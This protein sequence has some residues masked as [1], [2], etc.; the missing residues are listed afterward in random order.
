ML[1]GAG[2]PAGG[3]C[4]ARNRYS[5]R[6]S[7]TCAPDPS[8]EHHCHR[9]TPIL[10]PPPLVATITPPLLVARALQNLPLAPAE[11]S[12]R[13]GPRRLC[14]PLPLKDTTADWE[15]IA[16]PAI[17]ALP[18]TSHTY[19]RYQ[20]VPSASAITT[21]PPFFPSDLVIDRRL[22]HNTPPIPPKCLPQSSNAAASPSPRG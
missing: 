12:P 21:S 14:P 20:K 10:P 2:P 18:L 5:D 22:P 1:S 4:S 6:G 16:T 3:P 17:N 15:T 11:Q 7:N 9:P 19:T 8:P 13:P